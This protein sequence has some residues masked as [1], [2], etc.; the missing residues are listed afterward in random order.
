MFLWTEGM[1]IILTGE[2]IRMFVP[3]VN[4]S[5]VVAWIAYRADGSIE[6]I[7]HSSQSELLNRFV[8]RFVANVV[9]DLYEI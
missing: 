2:Y 1:T 5:I 6:Q 9:K 8:K 3:E 7:N 4:G